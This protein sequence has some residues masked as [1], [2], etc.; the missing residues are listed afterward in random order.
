MYSKISLFLYPLFMAI[1]FTFLE[2]KIIGQTQTVKGKVLNTSTKLPI[3]GIKVHIKATGEYS[4]T[5]SAGNYT[6]FL[7]EVPKNPEFILQDGYTLD[8]VSQNKQGTNLYISIFD[9]YMLS[10]EELMNVRVKVS[11]TIGRNVFETHST[12][13][14]IDKDILDPY[15]F[16][17]V[18]E[19]IRIISG[20]DIYQ[21]NIDDNVP[22][23]R[24]ILQNYY[25]NKILLMINNIPTWQPVYGNSILDRIDINDI[26]RIEVL[27]GPASVLY[28]SNAFVGVINIILKDRRKTGS[29]I[30]IRTGYYRF[31][32]TGAKISWGND[33][34]NFI[35][36]GNSSFEIQKPF[37]ITGKRQDLYDNDSVY[38]YQGEIKSTNLN[39]IMQHKDFQ[40]FI[41]NFEYQHTFQGISPSFISGG[42]KFVT[43]RGTLLSLQYEKSLNGKIHLF[44]NFAFDYYKRDFP[45]NANASEAIVLSGKRLYNSSKANFSL[46]SSTYM[47]IGFD[48][49][50][51]ILDNH[52][53]I[54]ILKDS[55]IHVN[56]KNA[57]P[58]DE[59]SLFSQLNF[60]LHKFEILGG[61]RFT[62]NSVVGNN[63]SSRIT[64]SYKF[65]EKHSLRIISGQSFRAP[66]MLE[67][68]FDH[69]T[70][71][72]NLNLKPEKSTSYEISHT[73]GKKYL[74]TQII[75]YYSRYDH[76]IQRYTPL[77]GPPS[78]YQN[79]SSFEGYGFEG[80]LRYKNEKIIE[81]F[82][83]YNYMEGIG[84]ESDI[85][86]LHI[87]RHTFRFGINKKFGGF[88]VS[89]YGY[90]V[91]KVIGN[92]KLMT[93]IPGQ[94]LF[95]LNL[96]YFHKFKEKNSKI[97]H[98][99][100]AKNITRSEMLIPEYIRQTDNINS[101]ATTGFGR[102]FIYTLIY[103]F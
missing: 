14:V 93:E 22:T 32:S 29:N 61:T 34:F 70:V 95:N 68:Y 99:F 77:T 28:G 13:T 69:P 96:G 8:S 10:L 67:L 21:T 46:L 41:N 65:N 56:I 71:T 17:N 50:K 18:S 103:S 42:G 91:S 2:D 90:L 74:F 89:F 52:H 12:I 30:R 7:Q 4:Y 27:R 26:E 75:A 54:D 23:A 57:K 44:S 3:T 79:L 76:F 87:P 62:Y 5:D 83:S 88:F 20:M 94:Q 19:A 15:N 40:L 85:N 82:T 84:G 11:S 53:A 78:Q 51:R 35:I 60:H 66:T 97:T 81:L 37:E 25:S 24:G 100:S 1:L 48:Y 101:I 80:E 64:L 45:S 72:G 39:F 58:I 47:E 16:L 31:G 33:N 36:S 38:Y 98:I 6:I 49:E 55:I 102:R 73:I 86:Y 59:I 43:D 9:P 92:P 63:I